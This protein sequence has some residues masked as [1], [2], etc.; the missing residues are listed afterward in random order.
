MDVFA[1][2]LLRTLCFHDGWG[3]APTRIE[4][5]HGWDAAPGTFPPYQG[6]TQRGLPSAFAD[7]LRQNRI[8]EQRGRIVFPGREAL[9]AEHEAREALFP[10]KIRRARSVAAWLAR[11]DGVRFVAL[12]NTT[13]LSHARDGGD[14]DFFVMARSGTVWQSRAWATLPFKLTGSRPK[15]GEVHRDAVCLSFFIDDAA[16]DLASCQLSGDD[17][18]FRHWFLSLLPLYDDGVSADLWEANA[19]IRNRH[20]FARRWIVNADLEQKKPH[21]RIPT[22]AF[23]ER[24]A[25]SL[26]MSA[27]PDAITSIMNRDAR[28]VLNAHTLKLHVD[29]GR[30]R[31]REQYLAR[32][33]HYA[34]TP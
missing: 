11:I 15:I 7:L 18:Y 8:I 14:L 21:V 31:Y 16:L 30:E 25:R 13:A 1:E 12:C 4:L 29:D 10:R 33:Q 23:L 32:C 3:Y 19:A 20:P 17:V 28:V 5:F 26:Q 6:G 27:F 2:G 22:P 24:T 34:V 9:I